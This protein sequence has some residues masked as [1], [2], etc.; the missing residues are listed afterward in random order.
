M[1]IYP[2]MLENSHTLA[3]LIELANLGDSP[4]AIAR[5]QSKY[6][7]YG[8]VDVV[9]LQD[10][11]RYVW[12]GGRSAEEIATELLF[13]HTL[14]HARSDSVFLKLPVRVDWRRGELAYKPLNEFQAALY[15]LL[16][17]SRLAKVCARPGCAAPYFVAGRI[18]QQYCSTDCAEAMQDQYRLNWWRANGNEWR[19]KRRRKGR[20]RA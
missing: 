13:G 11:L 7:G 20:K 6:P 15:A 3:P 16:Q 1:V 14:T 4:E 18:T 17:R 19:R 5:F 12:Q 9:T 8:D 2:S 10:K